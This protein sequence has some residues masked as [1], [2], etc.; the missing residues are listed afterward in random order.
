VALQAVS[1]AGLAP[2]VRAC[3]P[4]LG[5]LVTHYI[6]G[7]TWRA[8]D[9]AVQSNL[10]RVAE[11]L[12]CLHELPVPTGVQVVDYAQQ[13][14]H[15][16]AGLT[17]AD[18]EAAALHVRAGHVFE[19]LAGRGLANTL[20]HHDLHH[21]NLVDDGARLWLVDWEYAG[22][23][24]PL[25]DVAGFLAMHRLGPGPTAEFLR[26]YG[27][28]RAADRVCLDDARWAFDYVQWLWYR[29]SLGSRPD[30]GSVLADRE[31]RLASRL[32]RCNNRQVDSGKGGG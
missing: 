28:L 6:D 12:R 30:P 3:E 1:A 10:Q 2:A 24:D 15:L 5:L 7:T 25:L 4:D 11:R 22:R 32:L 27:R 18:R 17:A 9:V 26:C 20:C 13:A 8:A 14:R 21:L 23:G 31:A 19:R 16:E 29:S